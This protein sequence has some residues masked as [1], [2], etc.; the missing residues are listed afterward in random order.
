M[1]SGGTM[2]IYV[3]YTADMS[4]KMVLNLVLSLFFSTPTTGSERKDEERERVFS[5]T[6][7]LSGL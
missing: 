5:T 6:Y 2:N 7:N 4:G 1:I 3:D